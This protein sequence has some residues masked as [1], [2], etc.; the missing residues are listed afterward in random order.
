MNQEASPYLPVASEPAWFARRVLL[1]VSGLTPQ[2]VTET[3]YALAADEHAPFVPTE[4]HLITSAEGARRAELSLLSDDLGWFH[5]LCADYH[6]PGV[7]FDRR[8]IHVMRDAQG[9]PLT[10]IRS[11][12]D[13]QAAADFITAQVRNFTADPSCALHASIAG[14]R[15]TMG[16]YLGYA[17][18]L[19]GRPQDRLSHVLVSDP[20]ESSYDFFYPTPYSRVLQTRDGQLADTATAQVTLADIPFVSLRHGLPTALLSGQ[21]SFNDT[22]SAARAALAPPELVLDL[23]GQCIHAAGRNVALPPAELALLALFARRCIRALGPVE[24]PSK[25]VGDPAWAESYLREYRA[26]TGKLAD[27]EAT[28]KALRNGMDGEY[29]SVR[30]SKLEKR[31]VAALGPAAAA[32]RINDGGKRPRKYQLVLVPEAVRFASDVPFREGIDD[33]A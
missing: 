18:S 11:P 26:I 10:D 2:V 28:T 23:A 14:G 20:F 6:L 30:K 17:L 24:A 8:H 4:V 15:K 31:L 33:D 12:Q 13:N 19:Y 9:Q 29:F 22:V 1:A 5:R 3:L 27:I 21:A 16:F 7:R 25:G 32:Y